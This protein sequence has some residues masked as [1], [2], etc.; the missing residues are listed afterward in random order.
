MFR[1]LVSNLPFNPSLVG[2][3]SFYAK[4]IHQEASLRRMGFVLVAIAMFIQMFAVIAPPEKSLAAS[5]NHIIN[6]LKTR[7]DILAAWDRSGSDIPAIYG[8]F[9]VSRDDIAKLPMNPNASIKSTSDDWWTIGRN[10]LSNYSNVANQYKKTEITIKINANLN[11]YM[12]DLQAWDIKNPY[13]LYQAFTGTKASDKS[14]FWILVD[15]G[16]YT[17][18]G[19]FTPKNPNLEIKKSAITNTNPVKPGDKFTYRIEYRNT[20][21]DSLAQNVV[22]SDELDLDHYTVISPKGLPITGNTLNYPVGNLAYSANYKVLDIVVQLKNPYPAGTLKTCNVG[23]LT[24]SNAGTEQSGPACVTIVRPCQ[25]NPKILENNPE[26][27]PPKPPKPCK[28][29]PAYP[30]DDKIHCVPAKVYC[31]LVD[32]EIDRSTRVVKFK[33]EVTSTNDKNT[34]V[35]N[36]VYDFGDGSAKLTNTSKLLTDM[37]SHKY[38]VG[39]FNSRVVV[40]YTSTGVSGQQKVECSDHITFDQEKPAGEIKKVKNITQNLEGDQAIN[41]L[42]KAGDVLEYTLITTNSNDAARKNYVVSDYIG[43]VMDYADIDL[44]FLKDQG[45][46]YDTAT[47]KVMYENI[48]LPAKGEIA[49]SFRVKIKNPIPSTNSPSAVSGAFD[50]KISNKYGNETSMSV[51]CPVIKSLENLPNTGPGASLI[52]GFIV[53]LVAG[54]FLARSR[55]LARELDI[56]KTEYAPSGTI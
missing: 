56:I 52:G 55:L 33:T 31:S 29:D 26:C 19:K 30:E 47:K 38:P 8:K 32:T 44:A 3:V 9:G 45:G 37:A 41:T 49:K 21:P 4:R 34:V 25:Y 43:D 27:K 14:Q 22:I 11:V 40:N 5:D 48:T 24:S 17:Q 7:S 46:S 50:C 10:S 39:S 20:Q 51:T 12:R 2:Q 28:Y 1:K 54:Y 15:C 6:G 53:T 35:L 18:K 16:N 36:Y 23:K 42:V 13:N